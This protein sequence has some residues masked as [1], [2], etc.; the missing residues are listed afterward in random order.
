MNN[1]P[2]YTEKELFILISE[3]NETAYKELYYLYGKLLSPFLFKLTGSQYTTDEIIQEVFLR[4]WLYR[5]KLPEVDYPRS[6]IFKIASNRAFDW[7]KK[8]IL[9]DKTN[10]TYQ[11]GLAAAYNSVEETT[12]VN[13]IKAIVNAA[14]AALPPQRKRIYQM[15]RQQGMKVSEIAAHAGISV[16]TVKNTLLSAAKAISEKVE[17]AG[18]FICVWLILLLKC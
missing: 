13:E 7:L 10:R 9:I 15:H 4:V 1:N 16:S 17:K 6:W 12:I 2:Q 18:Y 14:I 8:N 5:Y 3:S 11:E